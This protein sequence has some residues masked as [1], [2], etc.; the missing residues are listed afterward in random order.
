MVDARGGSLSCSRHQGLRLAIPPGAAS[1]P[2]R[3]ICRL[4]RQ[5]KVPRPPPLND[6]EGLACR[7]MEMG[8]NHIKFNSPIMLEVPHHA[9][10]RGREREVV[11]LRSE[12]GEVWKEHPM[13]SNDQE[14][15]EAMGDASGMWGVMQNYSRTCR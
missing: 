11:V 12:N 13:S 8:P 5:D 1:G 3:V 14:V 15:A 10:L 9:A 6:G 7:I 4:L 2:V